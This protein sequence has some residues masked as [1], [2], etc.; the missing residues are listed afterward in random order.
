MEKK[1]Q[2]IPQAILDK[3]KELNCQVGER[4]VHPEYGVH[5]WLI[6]NN[7]EEL[8]KRLNLDSAHSRVGL[9][10]INEGVVKYDFPIN[11]KPLP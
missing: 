11:W 10:C 3:A 2:G 5:Y 4:I 9:I 6:P 7:F 1:K 8:K